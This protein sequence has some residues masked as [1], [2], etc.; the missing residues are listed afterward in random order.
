[1]YNYGYGHLELDPQDSFGRN[2]IIL[3]SVSVKSLKYSW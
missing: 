1:M 2:F 3:D